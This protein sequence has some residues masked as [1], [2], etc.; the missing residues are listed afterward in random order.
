MYVQSRIFERVA[1]AAGEAR[2]RLR[3]A[4]ESL[5]NRTALGRRVCEEFGFYGAP[6]WPQQASC[7][8]A[9]RTLEERGRITLP[10]PRN[11]DGGGAPRGIGQPVP[12]PAGVPSRVDAVEG[13][14]LVRVVGDGG[15]RVWNEL[16]SR[17]YPRGV[18]RHAGAQL[19]DLII[20]DHGVPGALGFSALTALT[21]ATPDR[22]MCCDAA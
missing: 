21:L 4:A 3:T 6:G 14:S 20:S 16:V 12:V 7:V 9:L 5:A 8:K 18:A 1:S 10:A 15:R 17:E 2:I 13:L 22:W 19:R 11:G